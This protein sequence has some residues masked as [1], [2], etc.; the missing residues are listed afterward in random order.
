[1][2]K[3]AEPIG[4]L[5]PQPWLS[6][7]ETQ[8]VVAALSADG[9]EVRFV[10]GCVRDAVLHR[11]IKDIDIAT[12]DQPDKVMALLARAGIHVIPTGIAHGTVTAVIGKA[13][14]EITTL[15]EDVETYGRHALVAFTDDWAAD[16]ARRDFTMNAMFADAQGR[17]YDP[18]DG[19]ADL[20][21]GHVR[22]VGDPQRRIE[23]DV[24]RLLRYFRFYAHY[25]RPPMNAQALWACRR[26]APE[27]V[28]LSGE[29]VAGELVKL[30]LAPDPA[31]V[32]IIMHADRIL[33]PILPEAEEFGRLRVLCWLETRAMVRDDVAPD[34]M[35]RLGALL[36][37]DAEGAAAVGERLKL[38]N[39]QTTRVVAIA[40][41]KV[42]VTSEMDSRAVRRALRMVGADTFRDLVLVAWATARATTERADSAETARWMAL[43]DAAAAWVPVELPVRGAD[44][45]DLGVPR[46]PR[47][48]AAL[49]AVE[50][51]WEANDYRPGRDECLEKLRQAITT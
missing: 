16:A 28:R 4:Q 18:F 8:R 36:R 29:R 35:R 9:A 10:G 51:W 34:S 11:P 46:G 42:A 27:L 32:L 19:L 38:S 15:R 44:C 40:A 33:A 48:G 12:H 14:F 49:A 31:S 47:I 22:F 37:T 24:L 6:A 1:M 5:S 23:E 2:A 41:P 3:G 30:L 50:A 17:V 13:H 43:L 20:G 21:R 39:A 7:P 25:G 45:L 26:M